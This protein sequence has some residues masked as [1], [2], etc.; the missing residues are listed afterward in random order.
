MSSAHSVFHKAKVSACRTP[1]TSLELTDTDTKRQCPKC[2]SVVYRFANMTEAE[3]TQLIDVSAGKKDERLCVR[4]DGTFVVGNHPCGEFFFTS[5]AWESWFNAMDCVLQ[6]LVR[7]P[8]WTVSLLGVC[9]A[10]ALLIPVAPFLSSIVLCVFV[11]RIVNSYNCSLNNQEWSATDGQFSKVPALVLTH[12]LY[13]AVSAFACVFFVIPG[14][15]TAIMLSLAAV[16]ICIENR[17]FLSALVQSVKMI[18]FT[19][20]IGKV[21]NLYGPAVI[22]G[23][24]GMM[25]WALAAISSAFLPKPVLILVE[26]I[27][28]CSTAFWTLTFVPLQVNVYRM[29]KADDQANLS[30]SKL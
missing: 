16:L 9:L 23:T 27:M 30:I 22:A 29:L 11:Y 4:A 19:P 7:T 15:L 1:W 10:Q 25:F 13:L 26:F 18:G 17:N 21:L 6:A 24:V 28:V 12:W 2:R 8:I 5:A 20:R 3:A 14:I